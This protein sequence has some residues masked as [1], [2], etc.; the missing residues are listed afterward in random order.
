MDALA[1]RILIWRSVIGADNKTWLQTHLSRIERSTDDAS[2]IRDDFPD[3]SL[4]T[5]ST[6][7]SPWFANIVN[8]LAASVFPPLASRA[9][10]DKL[11]SDA[12]Y[13]IW[14]DPYLWKM[15]SDQVTRRCIPDHEIDSVLKF[16][17][18]STPG[19]HLGTQRTARKV[20]DYGFYW[21]TIFKDAWRICSTCEEWQRAGGAISWRQQMP[22]QPMLFCEVFD[23]WG[24]DFMGPF[25]V[26]FGFTYILLTSCLLSIMFQNGWKPKPL[27][28]MMLELLWTLLGLTYFSSLEFLELLLVTRA[29]I[30]ATN[31]W[32]FCFKSMRLCTNFLHHITPKLM[33]K[34]RS[35]TEK[36]KGSWRRLCS[37]TG[38]IG[39]ID[40]RT[41][42]GLTGLL[43]RHL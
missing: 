25:P 35:Q 6:S 26:S 40:L 10:C 14:D 43:T 9:Q 1:P 29:P 16:C 4:L 41:L 13:Y 20:L 36:S 34:P 38:R 32:G 27:E 2:P 11:K 39:A 31:P 28:L 15:C 3:E 24:I 7:S 12:R 23:V 19:G 37:P 18:S 8:Y 33:G 5:L 17:H 30:F 22:Q 42:Y 21:P